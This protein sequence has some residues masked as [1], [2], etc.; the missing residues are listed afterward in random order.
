MAKNIKTIAALIALT[1]VLAFSACATPG[2]SQTVTRTNTQTITVTKTPD[3]T[4]TPVFPLT[5]KT[6]AFNR[7]NDLWLDIIQTLE[8]APTKILVG[9]QELADFMV[10]MGLEDMIYG[11]ASPK[12]TTLTG[13]KKAIMDKIPIITENWDVTEEEI[14]VAADAGVDLILTGYVLIG[15]PSTMDANDLNDLGIS[16][17]YAYDMMFEGSYQMDG[18]HLVSIGSVFD[19][20][21]DLGTLLGVSDRVEQYVTQQRSEMRAILAKIDESN[22]PQGRTV[23]MGFYRGSTGNVTWNYSGTVLAEC[24]ALCGGKFIEVDGGLV[25]STLEILL[26]YDPEVILYNYNA[27]IDM[28]LEKVEALQD[29]QAVKNGH[30]YGS[31]TMPTTSN[32]AGLFLS[33]WLRKV[34]GYLYPDVDFNN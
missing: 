5:I 14:Y 20:Y 27:G 28:P 9:G 4:G 24:V 10:Y 2:S 29:L 3:N 7:G 21:R 18:S 33:E 31:T 8:K 25:G 13:E 22:M 32:T 1:A 17:V 23:W 30:V 6:S 34:A 11:I 12:E 16:L 15:L 19:M 26:S